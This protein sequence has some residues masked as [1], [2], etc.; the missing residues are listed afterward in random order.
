MNVHPILYSFRRCPYAM[1]ARLALNSAQITYEHREIVLRDKPA[2]MLEISPK[3]TVPVLITPEKK[4]IEE[5]IDIMHWAL[6]QNDPAHLI[7][8]QHRTDIYT[9]IERN[10][11]A[12][13]HNLDRYKYPNRYPD[14]KLENLGE[15]A[16]DKNTGTLRDYDAR[17]AQNGGLSGEKTTLADLA[18]F[19]FVRQFAHVDRDWFYALPLP[20]LQAWLK[21]HIESD[22]FNTIM[23]KFETWAPESE[24]TYAN[25]NNKNNSLL[26]IDA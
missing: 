3:G 24:K 8:D 15:H 17:I 10:D 23:I 25:I 6:S 14:E 11:G 22:T 18:I 19:P 7:P 5:S 20:N 2:H 4:V 16:R 26:K 13:K 21:K 12:F 9:L 1:R